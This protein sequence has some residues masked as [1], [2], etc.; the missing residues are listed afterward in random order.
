ML[1]AL[2]LALGQLFDRRI[3]TMLGASVLLSIACFAI[4]WAG[5]AWTLTHTTLFSSDWLETTVDVLGG[6]LT[7]VLTWL[8][9][10]LL[11]SVFIGLLLEPI[12]RAVEQRH[13]PMLPKAPGLPFFAGLVASLRFLALVV[14][15]NLLLLLLWLV[16]PA[17]PVGY[18]LVNGLLLG[19]EY[20]ELVALRRL[21]PA[22]ANALR[23]RCSGELLLLGVAT[24]GLM[25][26][27]IANFVAPVL[28]TMVFVHRLQVWVLAARNDLP[29]RQPA[30]GG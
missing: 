12:A 16:P 15:L 18:L 3:L 22:E 19:R 29:P 4:A 11:A 5:V 14:A 21:S 30:G 24:A 10:P 13:Y 17:Y 25:M 2:F 28:V 8:T 7:L 26:V 27:P 1:R 6:A 9:F 20:F 23:K